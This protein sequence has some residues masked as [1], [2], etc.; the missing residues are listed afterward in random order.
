[1]SK[2]SLG[3]KALLLCIL[4]GMLDILQGTL[5][6]ANLYRTRTTVTALNGKTYAALYWAG[7]LK[8]AAKDQR[9]AIIFDLNST[10]PEERQK[11]E[12]LVASTEAEMTQIR[13]KY[14]IFDSRDSA[15][16][17][18]SAA[19]QARFFQAWLEIRDLVRAGKNKE[20]WDVYNG[21][22]MQATLDR[23]KMEDYLAELGEQRGQS[24][25]NDA[26]NSVSV[27]IPLVWTIL[28]FALVLGTG[29]FVL[30]ALSVRWSSQELQRVSD[31]LALATRTAGL[32]VWEYE[33][34]S[35]RITC[36]DQVL[37]I[38]G[39]AREAFAGT[40]EAWF[41]IV[42]PQDRAKLRRETKATNWKAGVAE[43]QYRIL[44]PDGSVRYIQSSAFAESYTA[45]GP[46]RIIGTN[47]DATARHQAELQ[48]QKSEERYRSAFQT[49]QDAIN[50]NRLSDGTYIECNKAFLDITGYSLEEVIGRT[51]LEL[52][53]WADPEDR[54]RMVERLAAGSNC[55]N[56]E[57][58]F[59]MKNGDVFWGV[60]SASIM[61][62]E[63]VPCILSVTRDISEA[64]SAEQ[65]IRSLAFY[66]P[67]T[68][69]PNRR[70]LMERLRQAMA[71]CSRKK[72]NG[73]LLFIDIDN[74]K[75]LNDTLGHNTGDKLL[76]EA[77][78]RLSG[79]VREFDTV[80]R[81]GGD[82]FV[83]VLED[84]SEHP[85]DAANQAEVVARKIL[86][87]VSN[88]YLLAG[89]ER[90]ST[91]S[92][93]IT[94][95]SG[96]E[97]KIDDLL[98]QADIAMYQSKTAGRNTLRFFA[99]RVQAAINARAAME[100]ELREAIRLQQFVLCYQPQ[101]EGGRLVGAEALI[102]WR[103]PS[104]GTL[105]PGLFIPLAEETLQILP[106]GEWALET[107]CRQ[108]AVWAKRPGTAGIKIAV[109][110]SPRQLLQQD[111][112]AMVISVLDRTGAKPENLTLELTESMMLDNVEE[113]IAKM[114][115]LR[116][117][118]LRFSLDDFGTGYSSLSYLKRLPF[119]EL[120]IDLTF[121]RDILSNLMTRAI[122]QT[123]IS[124]GQALGIA[125]TAEGVETEE[126]RVLL[127]RLGCHRF[128]GYL[129]SPALPI[130]QFEQWHERFAGE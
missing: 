19:A 60:M 114:T 21:K 120:K 130:D 57:A 102:R 22:L 15:A 39:I 1:M 5:S 79:C 96:Q 13:G 106:L 67:L 124:L 80:A 97:D 128:Q 41:A 111:F 65:K 35:G 78:H 108:I 129:I 104:R 20:A 27:G 119:D 47:L 118:G 10:T 11:Y 86:A 50:L 36:D 105:A 93:G 84:L 45:G 90:Y 94:I 62:V 117:H 99:P 71:A 28:S 88:T 115:A 107:A 83:V 70:L 44:W 77:A 7:K 95:F 123:V 59:R 112:V 63:G 17:A 122:A 8:G 76:Q 92:V 32:G 3:R 58:R 101:I 43:F 64:K 126:Q 18:T 24:L 49:A 38:H 54:E 46:A 66:D 121:V 69:L 74:F 87:S 125:V 52:D 81:L 103:H 113:I 12:A 31:R 42:H 100:D 85:Q 51:S 68:G 30:F 37:R 61:D 98:Q 23:R 110:I 73:A 127:A 26:F 6:L 48:L 25:S 29:S 55:R 109:N 33:V 82:E 72:R 75:T 91:S 16:I 116:S 34:A 89:S 53:I 40:L 9:I 56:L 4:L 14:P 2:W